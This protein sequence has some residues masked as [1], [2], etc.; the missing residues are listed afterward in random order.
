MVAMVPMKDYR[1]HV[2]QGDSGVATWGYKKRLLCAECELVQPRESAVSVS[3]L[4][5]I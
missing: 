3:Y 1:S 4:G 5:N 2:H